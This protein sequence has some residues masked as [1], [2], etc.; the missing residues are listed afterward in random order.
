MIPNK[1]RVSRM[2][3]EHWNKIYSSEEEALEGAKFASSES[4]G[5]A[6][7]VAELKSRAGKPEPDYSPEDIEVE[8]L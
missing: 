6:F 3:D 4:N 8:T 7:Y 2:F 1:R 5:R